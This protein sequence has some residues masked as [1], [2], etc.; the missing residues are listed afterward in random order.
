MATTAPQT[1]APQPSTPASAPKKKNGCVIAAVV[2]GVLAVCGIVSLIIGY[3]VI[4]RIGKT[5]DNPVI[6]NIYDMLYDSSP[7]SPS[8][9]P[10]NEPATGNNTG[11]TNNSDNG[12]STDNA[13]PDTPEPTP[14]PTPAPSPAPAPEPATGI[15]EGSLSFP[16]EGIPADMVICVYEIYTDTETCTTDH[17]FDARFFYGEGYQIEVPLGTYVAYAY[18]PE[19]AGY[20]AYYSDFVTCGLFYDC[21]SHDPIP[22]EVTF[23]GQVVTD[24]DPWDWYNY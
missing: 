11:D 4:G 19:D 2:L 23:D 17:V 7:S 24:V 20:L 13:H 10:L 16:S 21:P 1:P 8:W 12:N 14:E 3:I 6:H 9:I 22:V 5:S 15:I 18:I